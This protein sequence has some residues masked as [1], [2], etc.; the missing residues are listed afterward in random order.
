[1]RDVFRS[2]RSV[3]YKQS[4]R[5]GDYSLAVYIGRF[6]CL[7]VFVAVHSVDGSCFLS[8]DGSCFLSVDGSCFLTVHSIDGS[9]PV[10]FNRSPRVPVLIK[11]I[12]DY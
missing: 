10:D 3:I 9:V 12:A 11:P 1:M 7:N 8:V 2:T 4:L 5:S 6:T